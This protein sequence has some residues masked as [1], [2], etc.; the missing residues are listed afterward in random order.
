M[1]LYR[2]CMILAARDS[3]SFG[4]YFYTYEYLRRYFKRRN[5]TNQIFTDLISGG[6][7]GSIAWFHIMPLDVIKSRLQANCNENIKL[8]QLIKEIYYES[9]LKGFYKGLFPTVI[10]GFLVNACILCVYSQT[11]IFLNKI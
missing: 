8:A 1:G 2:G 7:A 4:L 9:G 5:Q 11:L 10:R 3:L 6:V